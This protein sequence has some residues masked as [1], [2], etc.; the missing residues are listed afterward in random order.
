MRRLRDGPYDDSALLRRHRT[1]RSS[2]SF[3]EDLRRPDGNC[4]KEYLISFCI[5]EQSLHRR[6][7]VSKAWAIYTGEVSMADETLWHWGS[8]SFSVAPARPIWG[9]SRKVP[10]R[11][12]LEVQEKRWVRCIAQGMLWKLRVD[13]YNYEDTRSLLR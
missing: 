1:V 6:V 11:Q 12:P 13:V 8:P 7:P 4:T 10:L 5:R 9:A 3:L 2:P